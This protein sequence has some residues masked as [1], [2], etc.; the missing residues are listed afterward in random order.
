MARYVSI[1]YSPAVPIVY[2]RVIVFLDEICDSECSS[3]IE[4][5]F[6]RSTSFSPSDGLD[7]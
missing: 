3:Q 1:F 6:M 2:L 4:D 5:S 7:L